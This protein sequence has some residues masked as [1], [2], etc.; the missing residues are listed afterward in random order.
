MEDR[1]ALIF[2][3]CWDQLH[4]LKLQV[5]RVFV[6]CESDMTE[7]IVMIFPTLHEV[8]SDYALSWI[9]RKT[10]AGMLLCLRTAIVSAFSLTTLEENR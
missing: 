9:F 8:R 2:W 3:N 6:P 1:V 4:T 10:I 7:H 5:F